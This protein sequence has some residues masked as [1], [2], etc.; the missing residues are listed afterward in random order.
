MH[1]SHARRAYWTGRFAVTPAHPAT[2]GAA[3]YTAG[4]TSN[5]FFFLLYEMQCL[6]GLIAATTNTFRTLPVMRGA[7]ITADEEHLS[8]RG[9]FLTIGAYLMIQ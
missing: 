3:G 9:L 8:T 7:A 6:K 4:Q 5:V 2:M 1:I